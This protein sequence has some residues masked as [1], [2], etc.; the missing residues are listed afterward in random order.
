MP[1]KFE[2]HVTEQDVTHYDAIREARGWDWSTLADYFDN[3]KADPASPYLAEW[4]RAQD[5]APKGKRAANK[6]TERATAEAPEKR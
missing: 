5:K 2:Y 6:G 1:A 3:E 4:A